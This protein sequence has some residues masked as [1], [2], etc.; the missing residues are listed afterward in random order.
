MN[1]LLRLMAK[2]MQYAENE[3]AASD[4]QLRT[5]EVARSRFEEAIAKG[6]GELDMAAVIEPLRKA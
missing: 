6:Y 1:F 2:D 5:A 4:V 3:A